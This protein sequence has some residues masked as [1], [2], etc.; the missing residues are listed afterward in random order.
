MTLDTDRATRVLAGLLTGTLLGVV[1]T[2]AATRY[3]TPPPAAAPVLSP[4]DIGRT[5]DYAAGVVCWVWVGPS[6]AGGLSCLPC[7]VVRG[8]DCGGAA[9]TGTG[10]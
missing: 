4:R 3:R 9:P 6:G 1:G 8:I 5:V 2:R 7:A 10:Y